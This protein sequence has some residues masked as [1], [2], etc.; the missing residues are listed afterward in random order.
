MDDSNFQDAKEFEIE[1]YIY[2]Y[3][4][5]QE[6]TVTMTRRDLID[7]YYACA[8]AEMMWRTRSNNAVSYLTY[9]VTL[10]TMK[11]SVGLK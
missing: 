3:E 8:Q 9:D 2:E 11:L 4:R 7:L 1:C 6:E 10:K 5:D